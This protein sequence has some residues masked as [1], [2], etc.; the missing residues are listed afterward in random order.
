MQLEL[1]VEAVVCPIDKHDVYWYE[2]QLLKGCVVIPIL[3]SNLVL[4][5]FLQEQMMS[6]LLQSNC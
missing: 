2:K 1:V 4:L 6:L 3:K 5:T